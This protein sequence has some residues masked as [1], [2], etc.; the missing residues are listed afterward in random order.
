MSIAFLATG[1]EIVHGD[2]LNTNSHAMAHILC[3]EGMS[4]GLHVTC[5]DK[6]DD[7]VQSLH[8]LQ[9]RH[10]TLIITGGLGPTSDDRTRFA[11]SK[12]LDLPL[13][14]HKEAV[15][16][17]K[18]RLQNTKVSYGTSNA[19]QAL[20]PK[21]AVLLPNPNGT[22]MGAIIRANNR[23]YILLPGPPRECL[24]MFNDHVLQTLLSG[25][26]AKNDILRWRLFGVAES[27][28]AAM[29]EAALA[30]SGFHIGYRLDTPYLEVKVRF[31]KGQAAHVRARIEPLVKP[32]IISPY[33]CRASEQLHELLINYTQTVAINDNV[34]GGILQSLIESPK[35]HNV[36]SFSKGISCDVQFDL[37]G[38]HEYW[39]ETISENGQ[40]KVS[41]DFQ[42]Q[43]FIGSEEHSIPY[44]ST[45]A[46]QF[47]AE[48]LSFRLFHLLKQLH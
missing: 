20:F 47:A 18:S 31:P 5:G 22:A 1:D 40:S 48:W 17:I 33:H 44:R 10:D 23:T 29:F 21:G 25:K 14:E 41:I 26:H 38:I 19:Q 45:M 35:N 46:R 16:H 36:L 37:H 30:G 11:L 7:L 3:S 6:E 28:F 34:T 24:P 9:Q 4:L 32:Y 12:H 13:I 39:D 27:A 42:N 43:G 15:H 8:Y 2:S